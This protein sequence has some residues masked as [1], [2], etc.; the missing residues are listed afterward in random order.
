MSL[1]Y[2]VREP[3]E[4]VSKM[5]EAVEA[6]DDGKVPYAQMTRVLLRGKDI[7]IVATQ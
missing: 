1:H 2:I 4:A 6:D 3:K 5:M 7:E